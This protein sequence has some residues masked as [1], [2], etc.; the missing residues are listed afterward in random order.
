[1]KRKT[2]LNELFDQ[3]NTFFNEEQSFIMSKVLTN[4]LFSL[5]II[6]VLTALIVMIITDFIFF[7][8][9]LSFNDYLS[10]CFGNVCYYYCFA[11]VKEK[12]IPYYKSN[13]LFLIGLFYP[14]FFNASFINL[15]LPT[16]NLNLLIIMISVI[17]YYLI[18]N[19]YYQKR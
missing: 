1:M 11:F 14:A 19:R 18:L 3:R 16:T 13:P 10:L 7:D 12:V 5:I 6:F 15:F 17:I 8:L 4:L 9:N 2:L